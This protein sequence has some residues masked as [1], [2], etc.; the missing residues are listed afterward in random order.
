MNTESFSYEL[1]LQALGRILDRRDRRM[2]EVCVLQAGD[3]FVVN[4]MENIASRSGPA[5]APVTIII[6]AEELTEALGEIKATKKRKKS[7]ASGLRWF[8]RG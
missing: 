1:H 3:G 6:E 7:R 4:M 8:N 5:F 2:K